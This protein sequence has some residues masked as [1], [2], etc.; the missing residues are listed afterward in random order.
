MDGKLNISLLVGA[1]HVHFTPMSK[2]LVL[3]ETNTRKSPSSP[4]GFAKKKICDNTQTVWTLSPRPLPAT[5]ATN[6]SKRSK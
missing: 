5:Q 4:Q 1:V 2:V 3:A 6:R